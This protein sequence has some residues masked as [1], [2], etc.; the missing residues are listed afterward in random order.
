MDHEHLQST[1][2]LG[3]KVHVKVLGTEHVHTS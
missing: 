3:N 1:G 2:D